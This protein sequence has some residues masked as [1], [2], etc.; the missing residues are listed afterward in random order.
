MKVKFREKIFYND[1]SIRLIIP[2]IFN[3]INGNP[4]KWFNQYNYNIEN[5]EKKTRLIIS[6]FIK[7][8]LIDINKNIIDSGAFIGDNALP[9]AKQITGNIYAIDPSENNE[10]LIKY[11]CEI[12]NISNLF[13]FRLVLSN[14]NKELTYTG[15]LDFNSFSSTNGN[16]KIFA[17]SLDFLFK[18][19]D[20]KDITFIHLDVEGEEYNTLLG[21]IEVIKSYFP[22]IIYEQHIKTD[23]VNN[24][25]N[26]LNNLNY[27]QYIINEKTGENVD[28]R[29]LLAIP[30]EKYELFK[31]KCSF[32]N[33]LIDIN[34]LENERNKIN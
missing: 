28:C 5:N 34:Y 30:N 27:H 9:W 8:N 13:Y 4:Y 18:N 25:V 7:N 10:K 1:N 6:E 2:N 3:D 23:N 31:N 33:D 16:N 20:I 11:L 24:C 26:L 14:Q 19:K 17:T 32:L 15:D 29:N 21:S 22:I 12:N